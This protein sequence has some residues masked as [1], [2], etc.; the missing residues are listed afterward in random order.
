MLIIGTKVDELVPN[1]ANLDITFKKS[2][3]MAHSHNFLVVF[4]VSVI[5][6]I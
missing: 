5:I 6:I 2:F 1:C 4:L 3:F